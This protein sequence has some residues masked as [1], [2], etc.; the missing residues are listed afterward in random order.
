MSTATVEPPSLRRDGRDQ[1]RRWRWPLAVALIVI[2]GIGLIALTVPT[3]DDSRRLSPANAAPAGTRA[4]AQVL[5]RQGVE[6]REAHSTGEAVDRTTAGSTL[7]VTDTV[8]LADEQLDRLAHDDAARLV[9]VEP[10]DLALS[11]LAPQVRAAGYSNLTD[12]RPA[13]CAVGA[14]VTAG[15]VRGG[16]Y[17]YARSG[18]A[19]DGGVSVCYPQADSDDHDDVDT[20]TERGNYVLTESNGKQIVV[21]GQSDLITNEHVAENG[22]ASLALNTLGSQESLVWYLPDPLEQVGAGQR[23]TLGEL[24]PDWVRWAVIQLA[25]VAL[26]AML[27]RARRFGALVGEPLPVVVRAAETQEGRARLYRQV[28]ARGR[29]AATLRT[30]ALRRLATRV[31]APPGTSPPQLVVMLAATTGRDPHEIHRVLLGP[32][33]ETDGALVELADRLDELERAA[34]IRHRPS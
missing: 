32:P 28:S 33:P 27:W 24:M 26:V 9:L 3:T 18:G 20:G 34:G 19:R 15:D 14:A 30:A 22:N 21:I 7:L 10:D 12:S 8:L 11:V 5:E 13:S 25:L 2:I 6:V 31:A 16:G 1:W 29:A 23:A 4:L 17:L